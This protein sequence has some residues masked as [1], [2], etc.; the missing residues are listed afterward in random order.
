MALTPEQIP[1]IK[2]TVP[3]L[4]EHGATITKLFYDNML[5]AHPELHSVFNV[6]NK[7]HGHQPLALAGALFAYASNIDNLGV[8]SPAV[9]RICHKHASLAIQPEG[10][11][12]VGKFLLEAMGQV[13]GDALT[14][15]L[16]DA[17]AAAYWQLANLMIA[18]EDALYKSADGWTDFRDFR[19]ARKVPE[20]DLITS[21]YL[22]PVDAKP[23]PSFL[24]GQYVSIQVPVPQLNHPQCRQYSL[25]DQPAP[26]YYRIS[27]RKDPGLNPSDP[28]APTHPGYVSNILH[29]TIHVGDTVKLTHPY[30]DFHLSDPS[31]S[32]P[33][34][35]ISAGV[36]LTPLTSMVNTLRTPSS[37]TRPIHFIHGAHT[38]SSR[39]FHAHL[40]SLPNLRTTHFLTA[41]SESDKEG[42]TYTQAG[43]VDLSKIADADLFLDDKA[44]E[45]YICGPTAFM[46]ASRS[47]LV[48]RG[49]DEARVHMEL[50]GT[51]GVPA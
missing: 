5:N 19:V 16:L 28:S 42:E 34:V 7:V 44:T 46:L 29:D 18:K 14:P 47:A 45:Y 8:L 36:G 41:P 37:S 27:V 25:S 12:I 23:L 3:V 1:L 2:A 38:S 51:G 6:S 30:G 21:F 31:A 48:A 43:R 20:S 33:L 9:E 4:Q 11:N 32:T 35:L 15:P 40:A 13:L 50:F 24:P 10:Y 49:V 22:E 26:T 17:W 39:A